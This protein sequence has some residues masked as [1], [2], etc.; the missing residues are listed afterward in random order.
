M[1][2]HSKT[3]DMVLKQQMNHVLFWK[4]FLYRKNDKARR[5]VAYGSDISAKAVFI[6][7]FNYLFAPLFA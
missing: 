2:H 4:S 6:K 7:R 3:N 5:W 1:Y